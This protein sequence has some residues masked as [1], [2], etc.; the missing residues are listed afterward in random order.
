MLNLNANNKSK[1]NSENLISRIEQSESEEPFAIFNAQ[2]DEQSSA[3]I[4]KVSLNRAVSEHSPFFKKFANLLL[5]HD[6]NNYIIDFSDTVF[7]DSTFLGSIIY[8]FKQVKAKK[9]KLSIVID[10]S[11]ITILSEVFDISSINVFTS[12]KDAKN[13]IQYR[14]KN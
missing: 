1:I 2:F 4:M 6:I 9:K 11:K 14:K 7:L 8:L 3:M 13:N 12:L 5:V 10:Y